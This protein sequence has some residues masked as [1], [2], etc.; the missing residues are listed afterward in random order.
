MAIDFQPVCTLPD[1]RGHFIKNPD[2]RSTMEIVW[3]CLS[4]TILCTWSVIHRH[5]PV[6]VEPLTKRQALRWLL[7]NAWK[8]FGL[9]L[10]T[11][12]GPEMPVTLALL[13]W[14]EARHVEPDLMAIAKEHGVPWSRTHTYFV[15]MGGIAIRFPDDG[16]DESSNS[17]SRSNPVEQPGSEMTIRCMRA[18]EKEMKS[19]HKYGRVPWRRHNHNRSALLA[20]GIQHTSDL[21]RLQ[22]NIWILG[23]YQLVAVSLAGLFGSSGLPSISAAEILDRNKSNGLVRILALIQIT[24]LVAQVITRGILGLPSSQLEISTIALAVTSGVIYIQCWTIPRDVMFPIYVDV[25]SS[26][27][28]PELIEAIKKATPAKEL[29]LEEVKGS[30]TLGGSMIG[31][32]DRDDW[33]DFAKVQVG[34]PSLTQNQIILLALTGTGLLLGAVHLAA[35]NFDFPTNAERI[36]WRTNSLVVMFAPLLFTIVG[37]VLGRTGELRDLLWFS[38]IVVY[39][40]ARVS[41]LV[42]S[43]RLLYFLPPEAFRSTWA[44]NAPHVG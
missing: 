12:L 16:D 15:A 5:V 11:L 1:V 4:V 38:V 10:L 27:V 23:S 2:V 9:F 21:V 25:P 19:L 14:M 31:E 33:V 32:T 37:I 28:T 44:G 43:I 6:H 17:N 20:A 29:D 35:W 40:L 41:L 22:G 34:W 36:L 7:Y 24:W 42:E 39:V 8:K 30:Y 13:G 26:R 18:M 3:A